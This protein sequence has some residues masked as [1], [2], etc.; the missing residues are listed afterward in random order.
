[1]SGY[2]GE[3]QENISTGMSL[4]L[5]QQTLSFDKWVKWKSQEGTEPCPVS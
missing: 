2:K 5:A 1:M 4:Q 3:T